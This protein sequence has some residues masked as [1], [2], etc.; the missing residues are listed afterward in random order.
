[1]IHDI[2]N[3]VFVQVVFSNQCR[4]IDYY[5]REDNNI[6]HHQFKAFDKQQHQP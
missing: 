6:N 5:K 4:S 2:S 1:M 3:S